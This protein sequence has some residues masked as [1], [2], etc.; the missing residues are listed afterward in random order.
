MA[1]SEKAVGKKKTAEAVNKDDSLKGAFLTGFMWPIK[2]MWRG[3]RFV[4]RK[5]GQV[6]AWISHKPPLKQIGHGLR[7]FSRLKFVRKIGRILGL[8]YL[9]DSWREL[10]QVTWPTFKDSTRLTGAVII[11]SL[12]FGVLIAIIDFGLDKLFRQI[13][14]K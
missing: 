14:L 6:L 1:E 12:V 4:F 11:F 8:R 13:L 9:R 5:I 2:M 3:V 10:R 7:W